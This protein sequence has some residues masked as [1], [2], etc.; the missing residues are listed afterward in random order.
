MADLRRGLL[1]FG[2]DLARAP[3]HVVEVAQRVD[4]EQQVHGRHG[5]VVDEAVG[6]TPEL[7][8]VDDGRYDET[9]GHHHQEDAR[10]RQQ[11]FGAQF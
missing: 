4:D 7:L 1:L 2:D 11:A 6:Q 5:Q 9:E 10:R 8:R 3:G